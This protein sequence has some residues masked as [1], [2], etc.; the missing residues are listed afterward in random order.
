MFL[1]IKALHIIFVVTWFAGL[2]YMPRLFIYSAEANEKPEPDRSILLKQNLLMQQRLWNI[3]TTPS[4]IITLILGLT[5]LHLYGSFPTWLIIKLCFVI[6]LYVYHLFCHNIYKQQQKYQFKYNS[7]QL[8]IIN[9]ISTLFLFSIVFL[10][11]VKTNLSWLFGLIGVVVLA[12]LLML[13][14]K[15][16]ATLRKD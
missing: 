8:R 6:G 7:K 4:A 16:Y 13:G 1:Y 10:V 3:I 5:I 15:L 9:E 12:I 14:I 11:V 2:F